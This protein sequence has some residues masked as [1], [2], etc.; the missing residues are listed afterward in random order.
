MF[1][2]S[3]PPLHAALPVITSLTLV[4][5]LYTQYALRILEKLY[6]ACHAGV[7]ENLYAFKVLKTGENGTDPTV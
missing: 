7:G 1:P 4:E 5:L 3:L 6:Y 2:V